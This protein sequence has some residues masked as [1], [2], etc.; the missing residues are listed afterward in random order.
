MSNEKQE[1]IVKHAPNPDD[2]YIISLTGRMDCDFMTENQ[3]QSICD[4]LNDYETKEKRND[5]AI[6]DHL[7][8]MMKIDRDLYEKM[9]DTQGFAY[10][11]NE[12]LNIQRPH[13][14][15]RNF[16]IDRLKKENEELKL[17]VLEKAVEEVNP[18]TDN[19]R[20]RETLKTRRQMTIILTEQQVRNWWYE[21]PNLTARMHSP[22]EL[23]AS[24]KAGRITWYGNKVKIKP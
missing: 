14:G 3:A 24:I 18:A 4:K 10:H 12:I 1:W 6:F 23:I 11:W 19:Q 20:L 9:M 21:Q 13:F 22:D 5:K 8:E 16:A 2:I 7:G 17:Q 15:S